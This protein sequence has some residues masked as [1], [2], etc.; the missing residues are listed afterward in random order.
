MPSSTLPGCRAARGSPSRARPTALGAGELVEARGVDG[1][2]ERAGL[3][4][5][6]VGQVDLVAVGLVADALPHQPYEVLGRAR[7]LEADH[8]GAEQPL[9]DLA[10]PRQLLEQL[11]GRERDVQEEAD[12]H[13]GAE[14][15]QHRRDQLHLV[16]VHPHGGVLGGHLGGLVGEP[17]VDPDVGVPPLAVELR[18]G[19]DV[20][21]ERPQRGV[22]EPLV[23]LLDLVSALSGTGT[24]DRPS[25]TNGSRSLS[26]LPDQPIQAPSFSRITGSMAVTRP[27]GERRQST[28]PSGLTT[29]STGSRFAT[30]TR[31]ACLVG[32]VLE[33]VGLTVSTY[34]EEAVP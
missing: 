2:R 9:E 8:V 22:G 13:V 32:D 24:S 11:G 15:A 14:L 33:G 4:D 17:L 25:S 12:A 26:L 6:A 23:E 20:V 5:P 1:D 29:R 34:P 16:V 18:L 10:A 28:D 30:M 21:V 31:S 3:H 19:D 7:P 27:P